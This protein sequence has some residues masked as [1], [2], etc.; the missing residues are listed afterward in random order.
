VGSVVGKTDSSQF[1]VT[2]SEARCE[3]DE[4]C[5]GAKRECARV[6]GGKRAKRKESC[7]HE[8]LSRFVL[9]CTE[10]RVVS[11]T[12][13]D[14][15]SQPSSSIQLAILFSQHLRGHQALSHTYKSSGAS[16]S[17]SL[18]QSSAYNGSL[19]AGFVLVCATANLHPAR[20]SLL[21]AV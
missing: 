8:L 14:G 13:Q 1:S 6:C 21:S 3:Q 18:S 19:A 2:S 7:R 4:H 20:W 15:A 17:G 5:E 12:F 11:G 9:K 10:P 16:Y